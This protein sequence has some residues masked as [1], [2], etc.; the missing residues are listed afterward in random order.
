MNNHEVNNNVTSAWR[1]QVWASF[2]ISSIM[3]IT[4]IGYMSGDNWIKGYLV[5][6]FIFTIGSCFGLAK[7][8][9]DEH[10]SKKLINRVHQAKAE[11]ILSE[12]ER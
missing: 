3:T 10:E 12:Y 5:M 2:L 8:L 4:G 6:G 1:F 11:K 7:T 9:R